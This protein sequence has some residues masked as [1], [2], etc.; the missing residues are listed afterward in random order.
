MTK[1]RPSAT[2]RFEP[3]LDGKDRYV[4]RLYISGLSLRSREALT[5]IDTVCRTRLEGRYSLEVIDVYEH[6]Q[7]ARDEQITALPMLVRTLPPPV[8]RLVGN[9]SHTERVLMRLDLRPAK[10]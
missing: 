6:P 3:L 4:L 5:A 1:K 2:E 7:L 9:L 8:R 10:A